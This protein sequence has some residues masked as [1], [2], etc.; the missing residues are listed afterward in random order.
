M[1]RSKSYL[2]RPFSG[3]D[4]HVQPV[5]WRRERAGPPWIERAGRTAGV[6]GSMR[7]P[8]VTWMQQRLDDHGRRATGFVRL[9][10]NPVT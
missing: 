6:T 10:A 7:M 5:L 2:H 8:P 9:P 1:R 4:W 3:A